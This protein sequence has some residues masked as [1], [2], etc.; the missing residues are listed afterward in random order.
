MA[1][2]AAHH[3]TLLKVR[4]RMPAHDP[5]RDCWAC[6]D[7]TA[8]ERAHILARGAGGN[9][10]PSNLF[11]LCNECHHEQ[12]DGSCLEGQIKWL[13]HH[14]THA[15]RLSRI[16]REVVELVMAQPHASQWSSARLLD[17]K[18]LRTIVDGVRTRLGRPSLSGIRSSLRYELAADYDRWCKQ[19]AQELGKR[20]V[21][22]KDIAA[23]AS[24]ARRE[25]ERLFVDQPALGQR[26]NKS[27]K[28]IRKEGKKTG[29]DVP[30]GYQLG[31][32]GKTLE[33]LPCEQAV[34]AAARELHASGTISMGEIGR[35]LARRKPRMLSRTGRIFHSKQIIRMLRDTSMQNA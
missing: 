31:R 22:A 5:L 19:H 34:I 16:A 10:D 7:R 17:D 32:D 23:A 18:S 4:I 33:P 26:I 29:G 3:E 24:A 30:Y 14:E 11:L 12:P 9:A 27:L 1:L 25:A 2:A 15:Q 21:V 28:K 6:G 20:P 35:A 8:L 13:I